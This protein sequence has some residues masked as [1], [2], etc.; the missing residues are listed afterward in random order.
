MVTV[1][2]SLREV[3]L[4][5][6]KDAKSSYFLLFGNQTI[7]PKATE[8]RWVSH[9]VALLQEGTRYDYSLIA[10]YGGVNSSTYKNYA[11]TSK[12]DST[13]PH[14]SPP[15]CAITHIALLHKVISL[16]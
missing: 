10:T 2:P 15:Q 13:H 3:E 16:W 4:R 14:S 7:S 12:T 6:S 5:W 9:T 1:R 11:V 8:A